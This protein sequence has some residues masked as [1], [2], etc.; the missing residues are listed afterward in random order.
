MERETQEEADCIVE[1]KVEREL[2]KAVDEVYEIAGSR[3]PDG[4]VLVETVIDANEW[5]KFAAGDVEG[6]YDF[7]KFKVFRFEDKLYIAQGLEIDVE[8]K[9]KKT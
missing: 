2:R 7:Y 1:D 9:G 8:A 4:L 6:L 3:K 5:I